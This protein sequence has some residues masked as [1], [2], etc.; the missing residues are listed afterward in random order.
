[1]KDYFDRIQ[2]EIDGI[3]PTKAGSNPE[4]DPMNQIKLIAQSVRNK[5]EEFA[6]SDKSKGYDF[7]LEKDLSCMC[8]IASFSLYETFK[9]NGIKSRVIYGQLKHEHFCGDEHCWVEIPSEKI[10]VDIT[11][12]QFG[13]PEKVHI[14]S[15]KNKRYINGKIIKRYKDLDWDHGQ[16]PT[17]KVINAIL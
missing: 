7:H 1:M 5:C 3:R 15:N 13:I 16:K 17:K 6:L 11:A 12:T 8:A 4:Y 10:I 9:K 14:V 2:D